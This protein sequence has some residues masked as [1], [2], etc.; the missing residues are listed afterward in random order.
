MPGGPRTLPV[1]SAL[2]LAVLACSA[3]QAPPEPAPSLGPETV[4]GWRMVDLS[5]PYGEDTLYWPTD[6]RGFELAALAEGRTKAGFFYAAKEFASAEHGGTH[7]DAPYH[8]DEDGAFV[9]EIPLR[10]LIAPG[11]VIDGSAEA[12]A[13]HACYNRV[14]RGLP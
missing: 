9:G 13:D 1:F 11:V 6:A 7:L 5:H 3:P 8:F 10:R 4:A 2:A 14:Q 12:E